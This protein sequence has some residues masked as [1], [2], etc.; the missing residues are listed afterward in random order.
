[1]PPRDQGH[2]PSR[3]ICAVEPLDR[4]LEQQ[5]PQLKFFAPIA[6][7]A[8][9]PRAPRSRDRSLAGRDLGRNIPGWLRAVGEFEALACLPGIRVRAPRPSVSQNRGYGTVLRGPPARP[10]AHPGRPLRPQRSVPRRP[11][12]ARF[13]QRLQ[14]VGQE[15]DAA[16]GRDQPGSGPGAGSG[17]GRRPFA[18][19]VPSRDGDAHPRFARSGESLFYAAVSRLKAVVELHAM[20]GPCSF[21]STKSCREPIRTTGSSAP[22]GCSAAL[23]ERG[24][25]GLTTTHDLALTQIVERL[26]LARRQR[27]LRRRAGRRQDDLRLSHSPRHRQKSNALELM[28]LMGLDV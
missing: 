10:S 25:I 17:S 27:P 26:G 4:L 2:P 20:E 18:V 11:D 5:P 15:Y 21:C 6:F 3:H 1:M 7:G 28:R 12:A 24:A 13:D 9:A 14:Y 23:V 16:D 8:A 22:R 19:G